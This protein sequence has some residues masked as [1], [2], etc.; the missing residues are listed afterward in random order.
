MRTISAIIATALLA[1]VPPP[2]VHS[3]ESSETFLDQVVE[4]TSPKNIRILLEQ[5]VTEAL[6][7]VKGPYFLYNPH[8]G[9]KIASGLLGKRFMVHAN[10]SGLKWGE[11]FPGY[12]Q[13]YIEPRSENSS[14]FINGIQYS[15]GVAIYAVGNRINIVNDL[16]VES[17]VKGLLSA[18]MT[19][20]LEREVLAALAILA[21]TNAYYAVSRYQNAFWQTSASDVGF[22]GNALVGPQ[23]TL[24]KAVD[25]T[26]HLILVHPNEGKSLP[27]A[28]LWTE[29]SA[30]KTAAYQTMFRSD[31]QAPHK[32]VDAPHAALDR[33]D[34]KWSY[35]ISKQSLARLFG[36]NQ[37]T[38]L[39]LFVDHLSNKVYG[40]RAKDGK[41]SRDIH[42]LD[43]QKKL[44]AKH[45]QSSDFSMNQQ[46]DQVTFIGYGKG[47]G[48]GLCLY[49][50][51][52]MAQNGDNAV[53]IL[54]KFFPETYLMN[55][56][57]M[58][59]KKR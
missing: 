5:G 11:E 45:L 50:A 14:I 36:L 59:E 16:D 15:G 37:I 48:V 18:Q 7:E 24:D 41:E 46:E 52:A 43:L 33:K 54:S 44:G 57:A 40:M 35:S 12:Y 31:A 23:S 58:P 30:G 21:R 6:L 28:T 13:M 38:N 34:A 8:D 29:H 17:Y 39:E 53:K 19:Q 47:H 25:S 2:E 4:P 51:S 9:A 55:L 10:E 22:Q 56:N 49:S 27:F 3:F 20:P 26:K 1:S 32:G 42:F